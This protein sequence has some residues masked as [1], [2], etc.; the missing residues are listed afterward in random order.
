MPVMRSL[1]GRTVADF[2]FGPGAE[3]VV[4]AAGLR[5]ALVHPYIASNFSVPK[6]LPLPNIRRAVR[7][8]ERTHDL[9]GSRIDQRKAHQHTEPQDMLDLLL[10]DPESGLSRVDMIRL[11]ASSMHASFGSPGTAFSWMIVAMTRN[12]EVHEKLTAEARQVLAERG[13]LEDDGPLQYTR[14]F[15]KEVLRLY[16]PAWLGGRKARYDTPLGDWTIRRGQEVKFS[17]YLLQRDPRWWTDPGELRPERWLGKLPAAS[18][19]AYIPFGSGP[20]VCIG[21]HLSLYQ[22]AIVAARLAAPSHLIAGHSALPAAKDL[23]AAIW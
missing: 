18:H 22:L 13:G 1:A 15:V 19:R 5:S 23:A 2:L 3:D 12:P 6:W 21:L 4:A 14:A 16:P 17:P 11:L 20:R 7:A 9:I 8:E 10:A